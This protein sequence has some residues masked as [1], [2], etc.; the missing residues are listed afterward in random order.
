[1][2]GLDGGELRRRQSC[3]RHVEAQ[4]S[5]PCFSRVGVFVLRS[6]VTPRAQ[7]LVGGF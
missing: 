3:V 7:R 4:V 5:Q 1:M 2:L 6:Q